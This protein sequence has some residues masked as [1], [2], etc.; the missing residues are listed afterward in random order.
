M[1]VI[2]IFG[3]GKAGTAIARAALAAGDSVKLVS[4][5]P[6]E[7]QQ[8]IL[9]FVAP[10]A[11]AATPEQVADSDI[12]V[13]AVPLAQHH[14]LDP[15]LFRGRIVVDAMNYWAPTDGVLSAFDDDSLTS[16]EVVARHFA[17]A[18][19]VKSFSHLGYHDLD[20]QRRAESMGDR[21]ALGVAGDDQQAVEVV[22]DFVNRIGFDAVPLRSLA[23]GRLLQPGGP[24]F[25]AELAVDQMRH[26]LGEA[27]AAEPS[28]ATQGR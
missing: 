4:R 1:A 24:V 13:L 11:V 6:A 15:A 21:L 19:L 26:T 18:R 10:G 22:A 23:H 2:G 16:S 8:L 17:G 12:V 14:T 20:P 5:S 25:G 28:G 27:V 3:A 9:D 7:T